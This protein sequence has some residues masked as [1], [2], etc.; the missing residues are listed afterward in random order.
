MHPLLASRARLTLYLLVW[1]GIGG[2]LTVALVTLTPRPLGQALLF[3]L[4]LTGFYAAVCLSAL[5][6]CRAN[7]V[8]TTPP[9]RMLIATLSASAAATALWVVLGAAWGAL[10]AAVA[11]V[12]PAPA[13][14][15]R[16]L[17]T[18]AVAGFV[19]YLQSMAA[20]HVMLTVE[21]ARAAERRV[22]ESQVM[23]REAELRALRAQLHPHFLFNSLNSISALAGSDA[24]AARA[25]CQ[26][27]GDFLR[28][29]L[30]LGARERVALDDELALARHYL[31]IEQVR[32]GARL[33]VR[34][35][36]TDEARRCLVPPLLIQPLIENAVKHGVADRTE[37]GT[38][39]I[40]A[41]T[42]DGRLHV[43]VA[44]PRDPEAP[45]RRGQGLGLDNVRR[46]LTALD[47]R[48]TRLEVEPGPDRF[49]V[50][51]TLPATP[52]RGGA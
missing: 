23:A 43:S 28:T 21:S 14:Q 6:V 24:E 46:R 44:N 26:R 34:E 22:L 45:S 19:L 11:H 16:D 49:R 9:D 15:V 18:L 52:A 10:L 7:P 31:A 5:W 13:G 40:E 2:L 3:A 51:L 27:L 8:T 36:V 37:G 39:E 30:S 50:R 38:V 35:C 20:H 32:F 47:P 4:P 29:S 33:E 42:R 25:M 48:T 12:G 1:A 17:A 41:H